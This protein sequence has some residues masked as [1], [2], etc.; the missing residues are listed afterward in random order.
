LA[1]VG[2][3]VRPDVSLEHQHLARRYVIRGVESGGAIAE[4]GRYASFA[5]EEGESLTYL[6]PIDA[7]GVN[8]LHAVVVAPVLVRVEM[9]RAG[10]TCEL[11]ITKHWPGE[12]K[13]GRRPPLESKVLFR[14]V[15]GYLEVELSKKGKNAKPGLPVFYSRAG[16]L[17]EIPAAF[18]AAVEAVANGIRC[19][20]CSH[21]HY[22]A[23]SVVP[24]LVGAEIG[25]SSQVGSAG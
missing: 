13:G 14:G 20:G 10:R 7:V 23:P 5:G 4:I 6:Q 11:L 1:E 18:H 15:N 17:V 21:C 2:I 3:F 9:F 22:L 24:V 8:G 19:E 16:E 25:P 12:A